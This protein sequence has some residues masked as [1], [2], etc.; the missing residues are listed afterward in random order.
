MQ[1][2]VLRV[3][4]LLPFID[5]SGRCFTVSGRYP[6][7]GTEAYCKYSQELAERLEWL[8]TCCS[9]FDVYVCQVCN[10]W[11]LCNTI[12]FDFVNDSDAILFK[13]RWLP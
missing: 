6:I 7:L 11:V 12:V 2:Y 1:Q 9:T 10:G 13:L 8:A 3:D 4:N 5:Q